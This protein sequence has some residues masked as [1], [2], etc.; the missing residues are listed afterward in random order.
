MS[1]R[2]AFRSSMRSPMYVAAYGVG[3]G[4]NTPLW[5]SSSSSLTLASS[6][7]DHSSLASSDCREILPELFQALIRTEERAEDRGIREQHIPGAAPLR[8]H[9]EEH[10]ELAI[11]A[12]VT[13]CGLDT[14]IGCLART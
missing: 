3:R 1:S 9:P 5:M 10:V 4:R 2:P 6:V 7:M 14:S 8:R 12:S 11:P 13:G